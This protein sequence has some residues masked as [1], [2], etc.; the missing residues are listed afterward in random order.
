MDHEKKLEEKMQ[1]LWG[2]LLGS[3]ISV[4][5]FNVC[6]N[7]EVAFLMDENQLYNSLGNGS[8]PAL[9]MEKIL[10]KDEGGISCHFFLEFWQF[11][12]FWW[13]FCWLVILLLSTMGFITGMYV[14]FGVFFHS[15]KESQIYL[16]HAGVGG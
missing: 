6:F 3:L 16:S 11:D 10:A 7:A 13:P 14:F 8:K 5:G 2:D 9:S 12:I 15:T 4:D 1:R